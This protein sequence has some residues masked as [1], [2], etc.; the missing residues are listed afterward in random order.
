MSIPLSIV[1]VGA[2]GDLTARK[3]IPA[4]YR[5]YVKERL[6]PDTRIV[7][8]ARTKHTA[9]AFHDDLEQGI[10]ANDQPEFDRPTWEKFVRLVDYIPADA[11]SKSGL[12]ALVEWLACR[13]G[14]GAANRVYYL[15]VAPHLYEPIAMNLVEHGMAAETNGFRRL[16]IEKPFGRDRQSAADLN[17]RLHEHWD[18]KQLYRIDHYLGKETVQNI[19]AFRFANTLFEPLWNREFIDHVQITVAEKL[20]VG[21]RGDYYDANGV[22]RDMFQNHLLQVLALVAL[23]CP[24]R[25]DAYSLRNEKL[26]VLEAVAVNSAADVK[27]NLVTGQYSGYLGEKGVKEKSRMPT[28][29]ALRLWVNNARW[30]GVPFY[31]RSGKALAQRVSEVVIQ[32]RCPAHLPFTMSPDD[33][34]ECNRLTLRIQPNEGIRLN[35]QLKVPDGSESVRLQPADLAFDYQSEF[36]PGALPEAYERLLLDVIAGDAALFMRHDEV[37]RAWEIMDPFIAASES[38]DQPAPQVYERGTWGPAGADAFIEASGRRW[39]NT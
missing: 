17:R 37:E 22:L 25:Y 19:Q 34:L 6:P 13:E 32:F 28:F 3:L 10:L 9:R 29:A 30:K 1:I 18:E 4:L 26:K 38:P 23:E 31:L 12:S 5:N 15:S 21:D 39:Q 14:R 20:P 11:T 16:V 36:G 27:D 35:F 33:V 7:G 8:I 24:N 2:S